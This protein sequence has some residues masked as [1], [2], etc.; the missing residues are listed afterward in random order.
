MLY[1]YEYFV[2]KINHVIMFYS[3]NCIINS[4]KAENRADYMLKG[5]KHVELRERALQDQL[6]TSLIVDFFRIS[7]YCLDS[8]IVDWWT[9]ILRTFLSKSFKPSFT[10]DTAYIT[11]TMESFT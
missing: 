9:H 3:G 1:R 4:G 7:E 5:C 8:F 6:H 2:F 10:Y 11:T